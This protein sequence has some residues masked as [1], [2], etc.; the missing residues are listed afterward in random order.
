MDL[1][2]VIINSAFYKAL[3]LLPVFEPKN[4]KFSSKFT[5]TKI[6]LFMLI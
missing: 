1:L 6:D 5:E 3:F 4:L 2:S